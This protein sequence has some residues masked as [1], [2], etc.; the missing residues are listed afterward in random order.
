MLPINLY[1]TAYFFLPPVHT[2]ESHLTLRRS[3]SLSLGV[4]G[5]VQ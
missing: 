5:P 2:C 4:L 1:E 3:L